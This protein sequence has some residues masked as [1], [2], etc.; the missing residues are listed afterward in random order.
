MKLVGMPFSIQNT[1]GQHWLVTWQNAAH[2]PDGESI[3]FTI[4]APKNSGLSVADIQQFA[5]RRAIELLQGGLRKQ[6]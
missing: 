2:N 1:D 4:A 6:D 5:L 3:S